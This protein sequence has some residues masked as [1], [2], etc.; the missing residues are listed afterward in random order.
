V[1]RRDLLRE[2]QRIAASKNLQLD[3]V[4]TTGPHDIY[5]LG[6]KTFPIPRHTEI[7]EFTARGILKG[8][9]SL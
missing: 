7:N 2:L 9:E 5:K 8:V 1:K 6:T 4:R 3:L